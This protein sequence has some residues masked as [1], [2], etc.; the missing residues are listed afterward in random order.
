MPEM[1]PVVA[2]FKIVGC[3]IV[4]RHTFRKNETPSALNTFSHDVL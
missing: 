3:F 2:S 4:L 1:E